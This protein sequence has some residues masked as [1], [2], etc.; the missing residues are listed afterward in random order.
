MA[1]SPRR[2]AL[3]TALLEQVLRGELAPGARV[4][5]SQLARSLGA[6]RTPLHEALLQLEAEGFVRQELNRG[7]VVVPLRR[8]EVRQRYP[9]IWAL[10]TLALRS[11]YALV[12]LAAP[13]L[14]ALNSRFA[15]AASQPEQAR[16]Y[17]QQFHALLVSRCDNIR[18]QELLAVEQRAIERYERL[19]MRQPDLIAHSAA[20]HEQ[21]AAALDAG[22]LERAAGALEQNW[23]F[24]MEHVLLTAQTQSA[25]SG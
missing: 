16:R 9:I 15:Q 13:E 5:A 23:R 24:G 1:L 19:F 7:F 25:W 4:N 14:R 2:S 12:G 17:D 8:D 22:D 3:Y 21:I 18:L 20:Q 11:S 10:E 6:S